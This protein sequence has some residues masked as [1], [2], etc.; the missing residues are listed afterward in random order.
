LLYVVGIAAKIAKKEILISKEYFGQYGI[1]ER[2]SIRT[3][4]AFNEGHKNG[5]SYSAYITYSKPSEA[6]IAILSV[7]V[8]EIC[9]HQMGATFGSRK[10]CTFFLKGQECTHRD[11]HFLHSLHKGEGILLKKELDMNKKDIFDEQHKFAI[12]LLDVYNPEAK[13]KLLRPR[14]YKT[15]L[16]SSSNIYNNPIVK[17]LSPENEVDSNDDTASTSAKEENSTNGEPLEKRSIFK[18]R[19]TSRFGFVKKNNA[20]TDV[21]L[22]VSNLISRNFAMHR[23]IKQNE[24]AEEY[25]H[26]NSSFEA[27]LKNGNPWAEMIISNKS[28]QNENKNLVE[29]FNHI[30][31]MILKKTSPSI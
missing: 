1:I 17:E 29:D 28:K 14:K 18:S 4:K 7:D 13:E 2:I 25:L 9:G 22:F 3:A 16:P 12:K 15:I 10:Y 11:C 23:L 8:V 30:N 31:R 6:A 21:P 19:E 24:K 27:E 5:P 20:N 26:N